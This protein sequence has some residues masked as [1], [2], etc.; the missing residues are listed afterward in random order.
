MP[1]SH[2]LSLILFKNVFVWRG[3]NLHQILHAGGRFKYNLSFQKVWRLI[4]HHKQTIYR[5]GIFEK[6]IVN[7]IWSYKVQ[8]FNVKDFLFS[9]SFVLQLEVFWDLKT[10]QL[11]VYYY[12]FGST[13]DF[14]I[15][16]LCLACWHFLE[17]ISASCKICRWE[18][19][20]RCLKCIYFL[21]F[22][23]RPWNE[24]I[25]ELY[26]CIAASLKILLS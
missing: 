10:D 5:L 15:L 8:W 6:L 13:A 24:S 16:S 12:I 9:V 22:S 17:W 14:L 25:Y 1:N 2:K 7:L 21:V 26:I 23:F 18:T 19:K 3:Q 20:Q 4:L 11:V